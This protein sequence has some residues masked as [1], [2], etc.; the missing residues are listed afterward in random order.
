MEAPK[1]HFD[2]SEIDQSIRS[3][4]RV[5]PIVGAQL[6]QLGQDIEPVIKVGLHLS[7]RFGIGG[8]EILPA[9][10][11]RA[12]EMTIVAKPAD[13]FLLA[14]AALASH[15]QFPCRHVEV[16]FSRHGWPILSIVETAPTPSE[17]QATEEAA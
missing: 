16:V 4:A 10:A 5:A 9:P 6:V 1:L 17:A 15:G 8:L 11:D 12:D 14:M 13:G 2:F 7:E 3:F